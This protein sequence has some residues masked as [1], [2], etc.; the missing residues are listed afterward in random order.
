MSEEDKLRDMTLDDLKVPVELVRGL[1]EAQTV[2]V[3][4]HHNPDPDA[5][6]S[7]LA[8][9]EA[10]EMMGRQVRVLAYPDPPVNLK[11][12]TGFDRVVLSDEA[13]ELFAEEKPDTVVL[14]DCHRLDRTGPLEEIIEDIE[15]QFCVDHH[16]V[17]GRKAP[18]AGWIEAR[19]CS[20]CTLIHQVIEE[21]AEGDDDYEDP[22]FEMTVDMATNLYAGL[23]ND[24]GGFRFDN[25]QP[26]TFEFAGRLSALGVDTAQ[27]AR[28]TLFRHRRAGI[29]LMQKVLATF[30][31]HGEGRIVLLHVDQQMLE[32]SGGEMGDTEG[33]VNIATSVDEVELVGFL[34]E[35]G[36]NTWRVSL[37][38]RKDGD[39][40]VIAAKYGG[41]GHKMAA[42]CTL[43]GT[44]EEVKA[45]LV[46]DLTAALG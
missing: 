46:A 9:G 37:R 39:V 29:D 33:F 31:Y 11:D 4:P 32:E 17:A 40:Q 35:I 8:L 10:L 45:T 19:A 3:V 2:W 28:R 1:R 38:V 13:R 24:T 5:I 7:A 44:L 14:V 21:L 43:E 20:C 12:M 15:H 6:G 30:D 42:G 27:V 41:G 23:L 34:K 36:E 18:L 25:T 26:F 16:L 22:S